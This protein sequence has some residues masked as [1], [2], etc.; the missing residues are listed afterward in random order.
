MFSNPECEHGEIRVWHWDVR[1]SSDRWLMH[2]Q[3]SSSAVYGWF[4]PLREQWRRLLPAG[5]GCCLLL[6]LNN[7]S[8]FEIISL[9]SLTNWKR[10]M[11]SRIRSASGVRL[12]KMP[13]WVEV[14]VV[15]MMCWLQNMRAI[16]FCFRNR[17]NPPVWSLWPCERISMSIWWMY[18]CRLC[19]P[20]NL[21]RHYW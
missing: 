16:W 12:C 14:Y 19:R 1:V 5:H 13:W 10:C 15:S 18:A 17:C 9:F 11:F 3:S 7:E 8:V 20:S 2:T 21:M 6:H 4:M